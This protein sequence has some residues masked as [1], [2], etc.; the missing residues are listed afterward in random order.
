VEPVL[1]QVQVQEE[2]LA[3]VQVEGMVLVQEWVMLMV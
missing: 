3:L 2:V 1:A